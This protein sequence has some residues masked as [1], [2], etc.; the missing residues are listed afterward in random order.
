M[1][2]SLK[3]VSRSMFGTFG[4]QIA[5]PSSSRPNFA[6]GVPAWCPRPFLAEIS[7]VGGVSGE[8]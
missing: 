4:A 7:L 2:E 1:R 3:G 6:A 5:S 8:P